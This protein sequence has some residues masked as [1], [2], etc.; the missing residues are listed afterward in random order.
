M[1]KHLWGDYYYYPK[2]KTFSTEPKHDNDKPLCVDFVLQTIWEVYEKVF[3]KNIARVEKIISVLG[4]KINDK[5]KQTL[6]YPLVREILMNWI[7][8]D[9]AIFRSVVNCLPDPI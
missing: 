4:L 7:P 6:D 9:K 3:E 5:I 1:Q 8:L 2:T